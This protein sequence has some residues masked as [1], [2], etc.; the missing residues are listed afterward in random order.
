MEAEA[1][2]EVLE[3]EEVSGPPHPVRLQNPLP[4]RLLDRRFSRLHVR[5]R[6]PYRDQYLFRNRDHRLCPP[7]SPAAAVQRNSQRLDPPHFL[8]ELHREIGPRHC[9]PAGPVAAA[10]YRILAVAMA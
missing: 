1:A 5:N 4:V 8:V 7:I 3:A 9:R 10:L 6:D 2:V